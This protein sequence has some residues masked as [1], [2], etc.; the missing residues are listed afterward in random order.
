MSH[1]TSNKLYAGTCHLSIE[2]RLD[3]IDRSAIIVITNIRKG[4]DAQ[5]A[6]NRQVAGPA[7]TLHLH[8]E[9]VTDPLFQNS[10]FFDPRDLVQVKYEMLRRALI[11]KASITDA[12]SA[13]GFGGK[14]RRE[15]RRRGQNAKGRRNENGSE[16]P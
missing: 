6:K 5:L 2:K 15:A 7:G 10:D 1:A 12:A 8:P 9:T 11:D 3:Y 14:V 4:A 13:F 16:L